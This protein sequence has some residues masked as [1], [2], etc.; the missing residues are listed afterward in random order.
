MIPKYAL[1]LI[2]ALALSITVSGCSYPESQT[3]QGGSDSGL[4]ISPSVPAAASVYVDNVLVGT[5][6]EFDGANNILDVSTGS[7]KVAVRDGSSVLIEKT[8]YVG[9]NSILEVEP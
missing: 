2:T 8:V 7:H 6:G 4:F 9:R 3:I 5:A 1:F